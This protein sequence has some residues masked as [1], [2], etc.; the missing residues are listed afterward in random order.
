M[1]K[2]TCTAAILCCAV[3]TGRAKR[4]VQWLHAGRGSRRAC[5]PY[6]QHDDGNLRRQHDRT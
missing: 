2:I 1:K 4:P 5:R 6:L 3:A